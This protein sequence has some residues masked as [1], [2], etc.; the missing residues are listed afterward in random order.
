MSAVKILP[1]VQNYYHDYVFEGQSRLGYHSSGLAIMP[2]LPLNN[3]RAF[4]ETRI[5]WELDT[6]V[7]AGGYD[8]T[9]SLIVGE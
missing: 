1:A 7:R 6:V 5:A 9:C 4:L 3:N 8:R 2:E